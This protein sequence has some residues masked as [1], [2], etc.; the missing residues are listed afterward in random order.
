VRNMT[1][2]VMYSYVQRGLAGRS[3]RNLSVM[4]SA[5][6]S[7]LKMSVQEHTRFSSYTVHVMSRLST[8]LNHMGIHGLYFVTFA[9]HVNQGNERISGI[10]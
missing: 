10:T 4:F 8:S 2:N 9:V 5:N 7:L 1:S 3:V 6:S